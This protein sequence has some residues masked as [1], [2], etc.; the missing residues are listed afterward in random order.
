[1]PEHLHLDLGTPHPKET[2]LV[3]DTSSFLLI[4]WYWATVSCHGRKEIGDSVAMK[5]QK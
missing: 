2:T 5:Y 4:I 3:K 1:M